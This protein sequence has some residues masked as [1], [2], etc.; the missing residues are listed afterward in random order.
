MI[1]INKPTTIASTP[2]QSRKVGSGARAPAT[3]AVGGGSAAG[4]GGAV[5]AA[6]RAIRARRSGEANVQ[7]IV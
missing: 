6:R 4:L 3:P 1:A 7:V 2:N 5:I